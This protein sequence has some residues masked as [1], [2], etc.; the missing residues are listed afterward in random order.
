MLFFLFG[1]VL[2]QAQYKTQMTVAKDGSGDFISIQNAID[3]TK[4]FPDQPITIFIKNGIYKEKVRVYPWNTNLTLEGEH[5]DSTILVYDDFFKKINKGRNSTFHTSTLSVESNDFCAK[6]LTI[7]NSAGEVGQAIALSVSGDRCF[8]QNCKIIGH[9]DALYCTGENNR[10]YFFNCHIE[11]TTDFVFGNAIVL[12]EKS[13]IHS[14]SN[15][16]ITA[17]S[18][19]KNQ[20]FGFVFKECQLTAAQGVEHVYLGRPWRKYAKTVFIHCDYGNHIVSEGWKIWS[21]KENPTTTFYAEYAKE[22]IEGRVAWSHQLK[23]KQAK[24]Y[25]N[26]KIFRGWNPHQNKFE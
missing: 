7:K 9:Q 21:N 25:K 22:K 26:S 23:K 13:V 12:L 8:F 11:G 17:A 1:G 18:T 14:K 6:H 16:F 10:Q 2:L 15:S 19:T 24:R 3:H 20:K 4:S 5:Q